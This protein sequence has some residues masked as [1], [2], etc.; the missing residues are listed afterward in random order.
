MGG[1]QMIFVSIHCYSQG[2]QM[3]YFV[4]IGCNKHDKWSNSY[5]IEI[6]QITQISCVVSQQMPLLVTWFNFNPSMDK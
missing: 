4:L 6:T 1:E 5:Q 3:A 2:S